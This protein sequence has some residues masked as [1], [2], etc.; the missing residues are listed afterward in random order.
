MWDDYLELRAIVIN[1]DQQ[2][3]EDELEKR[4]TNGELE[5]VIAGIDVPYYDTVLNVR[6]HWRPDSYHKA[7]NGNFDACEVDFEVTGAVRL[8]YTKEVFKK[9]WAKFVEQREEANMEIEFIGE[10]GESISDVLKEE[11]IKKIKSK[12]EG[13]KKDL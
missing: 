8:A 9:K 12:N 3:N 7:L 2:G 4:I 6:D 10:D 1:I 11:I 13:A 5:Y